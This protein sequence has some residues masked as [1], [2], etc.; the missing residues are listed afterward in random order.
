MSGLDLTAGV[1]SFLPDHEEV[2]E[3]ELASRLGVAA[4]TVK[5]GRMPGEAVT[6]TAEVTRAVDPAYLCWLAQ[7]VARAAHIAVPHAWRT[8]IMVPVPRGS[9]THRT[10]WRTA[11][12]CSLPGTP[13]GCGQ[14]RPPRAG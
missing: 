3:E 6:V 2:G 5:A 13:I 11:G 4:A 8:G 12:E 7:V 10:R 9:S 14:M 1:G